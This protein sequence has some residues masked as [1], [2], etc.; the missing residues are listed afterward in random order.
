MVLHVFPIP[1][2][3]P[4]SQFSN[5]VSQISLYDQK[6]FLG[7]P[8]GREDKNP[9][10]NAGATGLISGPG[11]CHVPWAAPTPVLQSLGA[12]ANRA[13]ASRACAGQREKPPRGAARA[14]QGRAGPARHNSRKRS[15]QAK[16]K[17]YKNYYN[18]LPTYFPVLLF[19]M[20]HN[21]SHWYDRIYWCHINR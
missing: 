17:K 15:T 21:L 18:S 7:L 19:K 5:T 9:A 6:F 8:S 2:P 14:L 16:T 20:K 11:R 12:V 3:P 13:R 1:I 10:A 4:S